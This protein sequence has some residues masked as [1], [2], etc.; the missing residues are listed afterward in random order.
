MLTTPP[1]HSPATSTQSLS[2]L[3]SQS[4]DDFYGQLQTVMNTLPTNPDAKARGTV[5]LIN[6]VLAK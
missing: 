4:N 6:D 1:V 2:A 5:R 3:L